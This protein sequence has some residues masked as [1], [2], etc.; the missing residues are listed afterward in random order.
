MGIVFNRLFL[1]YQV[2]ALK[3]WYNK[4]LKES[5]D[6]SR[7]YHQLVPMV[8][9]YEYGITKVK[10]NFIKSKSDIIIMLITDRILFLVFRMWCRHSRTLDIRCAGWRTISV[11]RPRPLPKPRRELLKQCQ[12]SADQEIRP[13][14]DK[15]FMFI[16]IIIIGV[17]IFIDVYIYI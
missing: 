10:A 12:I 6:K 15:C 2:S 8:V 13:D 16:I 4:T 1:V 11:L 17:I 5:V 14:I 9:E 3:L 7:L